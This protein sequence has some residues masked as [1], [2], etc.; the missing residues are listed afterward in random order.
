MKRRKYL[1]RGTKKLLCLILAMFMVMP[2]G[3]SVGTVQAAEGTEEAGGSVQDGIR[4]GSASQFNS[5]EGE[6]NTLTNEEYAD[7]GLVNNSP[8]E[9]DPEDTSNLLEGYDPI[10]VSELYVGQMGKES[11]LLPMMWKVCLLT[12]ST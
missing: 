12:A 6:I 2:A 5:Y 4:S 3:A 11:F 1:Y 10:E 8:D 9:F 7:F